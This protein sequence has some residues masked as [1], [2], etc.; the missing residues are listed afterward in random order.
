MRRVRN[1]APRRRSSS[2]AR[3]RA[4]LSRSVL[5]TM[6]GITEHQLALWEYEEFVTP[7]TML[8]IE[9]ETH[10]VYDESA[11]RRI[12]TIRA[13]AEDL[14]VNLPGIGVV[15]HLLDQLRG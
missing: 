7:V 4:Y 1:S 6:T 14:G 5:C 10:R 2:R 11:I 13:L 15:L 9:G 3:S 8:E 12:R